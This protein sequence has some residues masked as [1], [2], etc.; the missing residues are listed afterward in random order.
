MKKFMVNEA[1]VQEANAYFY[2]LTT[3]QLEQEIIKVQQNVK[4]WLFENFKFSK[5]QIEWIEALDS[6]FIFLLSVQL[7]YTMAFRLP[8]HLEKPDNQLTKETLGI[9]RGSSHNPLETR[10]NTQGFVVASGQLVLTIS[11]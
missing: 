1:G 5:S 2:N 4:A 3:K 8:V 9:K 6:G 10:I 7:A 11:Y